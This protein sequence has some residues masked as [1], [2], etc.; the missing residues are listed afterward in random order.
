MSD[1][2]D[3]AQMHEDPHVIALGKAYSASTKVFYL[4]LSNALSPYTPTTEV[5]T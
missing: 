3:D 4:G 1:E 2:S 5:S